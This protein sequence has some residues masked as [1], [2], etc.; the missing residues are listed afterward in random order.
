MTLPKVNATA[1]SRTSTTANADPNSAASQ[2]VSS[3]LSVQGFLGAVLNQVNGWP[4]AGA[5][6]W[7]SL[8]HDKTFGEALPAAALA[9]QERGG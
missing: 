7:C 4:M 5:P 3:W 6:A 9:L 8:V 1:E 2:P